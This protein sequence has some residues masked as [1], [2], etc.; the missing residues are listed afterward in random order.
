V[1]ADF[2]QLDVN[3]KVE[4]FVKLT[5]GTD[6]K[7][8]PAVFPWPSFDD[9]VRVVTLAQYRAA[10]HNFYAFGA[11]GLQVYNY[12]VHWQRR[13]DNAPDPHRWLTFAYM[14][15]AALG[16]L[17]NLRDPQVVSQGDRHY[18]F[19]PLWPKPKVA[20]VY[21]GKDDRIVLQRAKPPA[22]GSQRFRVAEDWSNPKLQAIVQFKAVDM[23]KKESLELSLNGTE[24]PQKR[25][26]RRFQKTGQN[27]WQGRSLAPFYLYVIDLDEEVLAPAMIKGDNELTVRLV[28]REGQSEGTV[29]IDELEVYVY[30]KD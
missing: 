15:P 13:T 26:T 24:I 8:Y 16:Y 20:P 28:P 5:E 6:C 11:D 18:L 10:A 1:P 23:T 19:H 17:R 2:L 25:V 14:W 21:G 7:V 4:E 22:Q 3:I 12:Q 27:E 9:R 29:T 30:V